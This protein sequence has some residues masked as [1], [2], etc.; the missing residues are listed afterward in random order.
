MLG[1]GVIGG[2]CAQFEIDEFLKIDNPLP[3]SKQL[4]GTDIKTGQ[5]ARQGGLLFQI[6]I[7][8]NRKGRDFT[9]PQRIDNGT[10][11]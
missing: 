1:K 5:G 8:H 2:S 3:D 9:D 6:K 7:T 11:N 4:R 10:D